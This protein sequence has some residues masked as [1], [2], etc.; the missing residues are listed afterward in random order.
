M[1]RVLDFQKKLDVNFMIKV[2]KHIYKIR[3]LLDI[4][5]KLSPNRFQVLLKHQIYRKL[6]HQI[7][8]KAHIELEIC[9]LNLVPVSGLK[10]SISSS[11]T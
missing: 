8:E 1:E 6:Y 7:L 3:F 2:F 5:C 11:L 10:K 9:S 4:R